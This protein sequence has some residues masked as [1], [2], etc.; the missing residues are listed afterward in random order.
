MRRLNFSSCVI[1]FPFDY[2]T[3]MVKLNELKENIAQPRQPGI[4]FSF[5][6]SVPRK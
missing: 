2:I 4:T 5:S 3:K 6:D 1:N